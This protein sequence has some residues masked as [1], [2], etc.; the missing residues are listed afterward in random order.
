MAHI[1]NISR[2]KNN[3]LEFYDSQNG[4]IYDK[5]YIDKIYLKKSYENNIDYYPQFLF[6]I[7]NKVVKPKVLNKIARPSQRV[8]K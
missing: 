3:E 1:I 4:Q 6:R 7:D 2:N 8:P 5:R